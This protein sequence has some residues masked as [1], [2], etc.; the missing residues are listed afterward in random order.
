VQ[1]L[2]KGRLKQYF[3]TAS[4][5]KKEPAKQALYQTILKLN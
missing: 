2:R 4:I 5:T 3:Q 1:G